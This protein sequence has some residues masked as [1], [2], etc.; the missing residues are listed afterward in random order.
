MVVWSLHDLRRPEDGSSHAADQWTR[1]PS[2]CDRGGGVPVK[3]ASLW[4]RLRRIDGEAV[5]FYL[6][7]AYVM[8]LWSTWPS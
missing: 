5:L 6:A 1:G 3:R 2:P 7:V 4:S 8:W